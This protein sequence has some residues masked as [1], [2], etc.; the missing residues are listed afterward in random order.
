[1]IDILQNHQITLRN[2]Q[3][4][5]IS[6]P[7][8]NVKKLCSV[9]TNKFP[10][11]VSS[12]QLKICQRNLIYNLYYNKFSM[13]K[14][15]IIGFDLD[16]TLLR[17]NLN[18]V[19]PLEYNTIAKFL[20]DKKEYSKE[21]LKPIQSNFDFIQKGL[22]LDSSNGIILKLSSDGIILKA[23]HGTKK[24][25]TEDEIVKIYGPERKW[26][27]SSQFIEDP[28]STWNGPLSSKIRALL[29]YFDMPSS[30]VMAR[31]VDSINFKGIDEKKY[32]LYPDILDALIQMYKREHFAE[33]VSDYFEALKS[34]PEKYILKTQ[35]FVIEGLKELKKTKATYLLT[36]S[37]IDFANLTAS[38]ALGSNW[39]D[40]FDVVV[41]FAKKPGFFT[42]N[43]PFYK[44][45]NNKETYK[46]DDADVELD[47]IYSQGNW[48]TLKKLLVTKLEDKQLNHNDKSVY[49]GDNM[50][51]DIYAPKKYANIDTIA[52]VEELLDEEK[53]S[54]EKLQKFMEITHSELWGSYFSV[55]GEPTYWSDV[56]KKYSTI[57]VP[58]I[59][60]LFKKPQH[61]NN[62]I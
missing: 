12:Y 20:V 50:I 37:N 17:Y 52:V 46:I 14:Y 3:K 41:T 13:D 34:E 45:E 25:L 59:D 28:L 53:F 2:K 7:I 36:G 9:S 43:R 26:N 15:S 55:G 32:D 21:I 11:A 61:F 51:Q 22:I 1:M 16:G 39:K 60:Y 48:K 49:I 31:A 42:E 30:L 47:N 62:S 23:I 27:I 58:T 33:G 35:P 4:I 54:K 10:V 19:V 29:D 38:Y 44:V 24:M 5:N 40:L 57:S 6:C 56:I 18:N 8:Q